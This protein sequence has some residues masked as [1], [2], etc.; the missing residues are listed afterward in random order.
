MMNTI[1]GKFTANI[2]SYLRQT[3]QGPFLSFHLSDEIWVTGATDCRHVYG[4]IGITL[5]I[6]A[7]LDR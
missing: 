3:D 7:E 1:H 5:E 4:L 6:L 2:Y